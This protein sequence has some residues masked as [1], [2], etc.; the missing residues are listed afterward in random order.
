MSVGGR[1][2][3]NKVDLFAESEEGTTRWSASDEGVDSNKPP[4]I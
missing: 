1:H 3:W 4:V 2:V